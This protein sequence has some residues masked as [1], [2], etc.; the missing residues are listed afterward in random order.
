MN[1]QSEFQRQQ[2]WIQE[3]LRSEN[4]SAL[5]ITYLPHIQWLCG[6]TGSNGVLIVQRDEM[7][8]ITDRRYEIQASLEVS[9]AQIHISTHNLITFV[10]SQNLIKK[11]DLLLFQPEYITFDAIEQWKANLTEIKLFPRKNLL[12]PLVAIKSKRAIEGMRHSQSISDAVFNE[13]LPRIN[14][15][16]KENEL[17][18]IIDYQ[19]R[20]FGASAMAFDTIVAFG[21]NS[22]LPHARPT[23][24]K[25]KN[26][27]SILLD[28]GCI[29]NGYAS[30]MTRTIFHGT[31]TQEFQIAYHSVKTAQSNAVKMANN[32]VL[33]SEVDSAA[34]GSFKEYGFE[35]YFAHSTGH[36][37]G[38]EVHEWP[39]I[40]N[41]SI[42]QLLN[43]YTVTIEPGVY[44]PEKF[45]IRIEDTVLICSN[46]C[47]RLSS[48]GRDLI[49]I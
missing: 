1:R 11:S 44:F 21:E 49:V 37:I 9:D 8:L 18:A 45:G 36:G 47:E 12:N 20:L 48:I 39:S 38:I 40:S 13:I 30:D 31:P 22:A 16:I 32:E 4:A 27:E 42:A 25:L 19:H 23:D 28:F 3:T 24:R 46:Q 14:T 33:A 10:Q 5:L 6:F 15:G 7:H 35:E 29:A 17:A 2:N 34:R 26:D 41:K 43:G